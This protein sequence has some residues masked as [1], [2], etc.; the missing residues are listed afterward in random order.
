MTVAFNLEFSPARVSQLLRPFYQILKFDNLLRIDLRQ[1]PNKENLGFSSG[2]E[3]SFTHTR[4]WCLDCSTRHNVCREAQKSPESNC[5]PTR[6]VNIGKRLPIKLCLRYGFS[7]PQSTRYTTLS[8]CWG[9]LGPTIKLLDCNY[10]SMMEQINFDHLPKTFRD[11]IIVSKMLGVNYIWIDSLCII[12]DSMSDWQRE[13]SLM[14]QVYSNS[15][16][17]ISATAALD[18]SQG[19][20]FTRDPVTIRP[21]RFQACIDGMRSCF[22]ICDLRVWL[23]AVTFAPLNL[24][25]WVCQERILSKRNLHFSDGEVFWECCELLASETFPSGFS[26]TWCDMSLKQDISN[27]FLAFFAKRASSESNLPL[28]NDALA[29]AYQVWRK[30]VLLYSRTRLTFETDRLVAIGGLATYMN[31]VLA[32]KYLAGLWKRNLVEHLLWHGG[33]SSPQVKGPYIAPS[34]SWASVNSSV[35]NTYVEPRDCGTVLVEILNAYTISADGNEYGQLTGGC[36][37]LKGNLACIEYSKPRREYSSIVDPIVVIKGGG[38][39][40]DTDGSTVISGRSS[41]NHQSLHFHWDNRYCKFHRYLYLIPIYLRKSSLLN[42][43]SEPVDCLQGLILMPAEE[44]ETKFVER[45]GV[46]SAYGEECIQNVIEGCRYFD[47]LTKVENF[48]LIDDSNGGKIYKI[49]IV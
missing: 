36:M 31:E 42:P 43:G 7:L 21:L 3:E 17:N 6:L 4:Q 32:D 15:F 2:S 29:C 44:E 22:S 47:K 37:T 33:S 12:Q 25:A 39:L 5:L 35:D 26:I 9:I 1:L 24:R 30:V 40:S 11:A 41:V 19:L 27:F 34:W 28:N 23:T 38:R 8:H 48:E 16:C 46:F 45:C 18:S 14:H 10:Q 49:S 13:S 20:F